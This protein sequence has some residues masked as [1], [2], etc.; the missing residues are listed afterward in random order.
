MYISNSLFAYSG[1]SLDSDNTNTS[2]L[3]SYSIDRDSEVNEHRRM[4]PED[5]TAEG[6][7]EIFGSRKKWSD[8]DGRR[9]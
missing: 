6:R 3:W 9:V 5:A 4:P 8:G 1:M 7:K 2:V